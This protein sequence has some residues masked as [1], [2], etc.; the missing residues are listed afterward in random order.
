M[1]LFYLRLISL[2]VRGTTS[3]ADLL[4]VDGELHDTFKEA[5]LA[6]GISSGEES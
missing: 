3:W 6:L 5:S 1:E 4:T 2:N